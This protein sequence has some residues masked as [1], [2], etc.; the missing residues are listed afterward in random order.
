[1]IRICEGDADGIENCNTKRLDGSSTGCDNTND[2]F[3]APEYQG[4]RKRRS[5]ND[6]EPLGEEGEL[7]SSMVRFMSHQ[8]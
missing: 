2:D 8:L 4:A 3:F 7:V 1:M 6:E 5:N